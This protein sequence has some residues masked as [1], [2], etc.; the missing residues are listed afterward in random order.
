MEVLGWGCS[1]RPMTLVKA[2]IDGGF[3]EDHWRLGN[4][5]N[6]SWVSG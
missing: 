1:D 3:L 2:I 5:G 6:K 4:L